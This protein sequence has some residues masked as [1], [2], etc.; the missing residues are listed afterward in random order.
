MIYGDILGDWREEA[1]YMN[2]AYSE[3]M[4]FTTNIASSTRI[5][6]LP[7][8]PAYRNCLTIKGYYQSNQVDYFLGNNMATPPVPSITY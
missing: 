6:T 3:L 7:H 8:N 5:Y 4:I 1:V 2:A